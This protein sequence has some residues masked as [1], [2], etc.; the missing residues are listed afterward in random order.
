MEMED[1]IRMVE[2]ARDCYEAEKISEELNPRRLMDFYRRSGIAWED[3][4]KLI[5][6]EI[7]DELRELALRH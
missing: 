6:Q 3:Y 7:Y 2:A 4:K 1:I 5:A